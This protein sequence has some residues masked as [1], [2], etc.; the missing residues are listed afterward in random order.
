MGF[1]RGF[2]PV[3]HSKHFESNHRIQEIPLNPPT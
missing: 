2:E 3:N 1:E